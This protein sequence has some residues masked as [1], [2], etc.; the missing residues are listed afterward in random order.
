MH[1]SQFVCKCFC[2]HA[3]QL[4]AENSYSASNA[5]SGH[6]W[7]QDK[8]GRSKCGQRHWSVWWQSLPTVEFKLVVQPPLTH[9]GA[10]ERMKASWGRSGPMWVSLAP[11]GTMMLQRGSK[12]GKSG[13]IWQNQAKSN[14]IRNMKI[15]QNRAKSAKP[16]GTSGKIRQGKIRQTTMQPRI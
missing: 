2:T 13:K 6:L 7:E 11:K 4:R 5:A 15:G 1:S 16:K 10:N 14:K 3:R 12:R 8:R 9:A